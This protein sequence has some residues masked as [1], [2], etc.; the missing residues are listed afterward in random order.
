MR[1]G[2]VLAG[3]TALGVGFCAVQTALAVQGTWIPQFAAQGFDGPVYALCVYDNQLVAA[4][5]FSRAGDTETMNI[6]RWDGARWLPLGQGISNGSAADAFIPFVS[7]LCVHEGQ[8]IAAGAFTRAGE[9]LASSLAAWDGSAWHAYTASFNGTLYM[10]ASFGGELVVGGR[11]TFIDA[12]PLRYMS[13][14]DGS[15]WSAPN[16]GLNDQA[17]AAVV[18]DGRLAVAGAFTRADNIPASGIAV[19][20]GAWWEPLGAGVSGGQPRN[21]VFALTVFR[22]ELIAGGVF[23]HADGH[24]VNGIARWDGATWQPLGSGIISREA[25]WVFALTSYNDRL[26]VGG[27]F[28]HAGGEV[29][30]YVA[31]WDGAAWSDLGGGTDGWV[32]TLCVL[33]GALYAGGQFTAAGAQSTSGIAAWR[34]SPVPAATV[35]LAVER[36]APDRARVRFHAA[37]GGGERAFL[38][39][40]SGVDNSPGG[41]PGA[42][43]RLTP[44]P[45]VIPPGVESVVDDASAPATSAAYWLEGTREGA[46]T[47]HGPAILPPAQPWA[48]PALALTPAAPNPFVGATRFEFTLGDPGRVELRVLDLRGRLVTTLLEGP[49]SAGQHSATWDGRDAA[50]APAARGTYLLQLRGGG[51]VVAHVLTLTAR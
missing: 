3:A 50:G 22:G 48:A 43:Q 17:N 7:G 10:A 12:A 19:W 37:G 5:L 1:A 39:H 23:T 30:H 8:L 47:W 11:Y 28:T 31:A 27:A 15:R 40:R 26:I 42:W 38:V 29:V 20:N 33:D 2:R 6:A 46:S 25:T 35:E 24:L 44:S 13:R 32:R 49:M 34:S 14:W 51:R 4:G 21:W 45:L 36:V 16:R 18:W 9:A 41:P